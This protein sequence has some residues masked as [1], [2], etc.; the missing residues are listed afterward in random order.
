MIDKCKIMLGNDSG[1]SAIKLYQ[2]QQDELLIMEHPRWDRSPWYFREINDKSNCVL[3]DARENNIDKIKKLIGD[4]Y[5][6]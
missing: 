6:N 3:L 4:Y 1:F 5:G 2:Q